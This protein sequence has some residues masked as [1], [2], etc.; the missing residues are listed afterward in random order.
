[1]LGQQSKSKVGRGGAQVNNEQFENFPVLPELFPLLLQTFGSSLSFLLW[2][3]VC[4][5]AESEIFPSGQP[6]GAKNQRPHAC[7]I[8]AQVFSR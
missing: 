5:K 2:V 4:G 6:F 3:K 8:H 1:M 7:W